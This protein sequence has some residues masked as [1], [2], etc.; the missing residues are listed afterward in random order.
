MKKILFTLFLLFLINDYL[1]MIQP[2]NQASKFFEF[3]NDFNKRCRKN[4]AFELKR[5]YLGYSYKFDDK[6]SGKITYDIGSNSSGSAYTAYVKVAQLDW[7]VSSKVKFSL[8][9]I[10]N[11]QFKGQENLWGYRYVYKSFQDEYK[12]GAEIADLGFNS[13]FKLNSKLTMNVFFLNGE[14]YKNV[15]DNDGNIRQGV[16]FFYDLPKKGFETRIYFDSHDAKDASAITNSSF[17]LGYKGD[18]GRLGLEYN[19]LNNARN[20][21]SSQDGV[22]TEMGFLFMDQKNYQKITNYLFVTT[23]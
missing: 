14:G 20:Y 9:L 18:G 15:Q 16:S 8:G 6:I 3:K 4:T 2:E 13:E 21:K 23:K 17:F 12:F 11:K 7:K 10:G 1:K 22:I 19:K 5:V